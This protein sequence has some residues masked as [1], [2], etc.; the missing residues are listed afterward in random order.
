M[1]RKTQ[2][3]G[4][5]PKAVKRRVTAALPLP[6]TEWLETNGLGGYATMPVH[7][8]RTRRYHSLL[9]V[10]ATE[11]VGRHSLLK[12]ILLWVQTPAGTWPISNARFADGTE[13]PVSEG[14]LLSFS[15]D[16]WPRRQLRLPD[17]TEVELE[18][19]LVHEHNAFVLL[20]RRV[21]GEGPIWLHARPLVAGSQHHKLSRAHEHIEV[22]PRNTNGFQADFSN[23]APPLCLLSNAPWSDEPRWWFDFHLAEEAARGFDSVEDLMQAGV[24]TADIS[25]TEAA[26]VGLAG[27]D[28]REAPTDVLRFAKLCRKAES[29]RRRA[30]KKPMERAADAFVVQRGN[31]KS[32]I[33]GYPWFVDYG[34]DTFI[35][36]RGLLHA[37]G[38]IADAQSVLLNWASLVGTDGSLPNSFHEQ[39]G[40]PL[41][42][43]ADAPLWF[44]LTTAEHLHLAR[45]T[46]RPVD[47]KFLRA[48]ALAVLR[49][50]VR[51]EHPLLKLQD[52]GLVAHGG[53]NSQ[54]TWM[55][56]MDAGMAVTP[57]VGKAVEIQALWLNALA[58]FKKQDRSFEKLLVRGV[59]SFRKRFIVPSKTHLRD[60][61]D[62]DHVAGQDDS[63]LRPNQVFAL[64]GLPLRLVPRA[65]A[66]TM[67]EHVE[68]AL[69]TPHGLRTLDPGDARY[70]AQC[71][72]DS[73]ARDAAYHQGT[74]WP[75]L[76][77]PFVEAWV[78]ARGHSAKA[79]REARK[80]FLKPL[81]EH[82]GSPGLGHM[83][84]IADGDEPYAPRGT[85]FQ[86][87]SLSEAL[88]LD[89]RVLA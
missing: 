42:N 75:W 44:A 68:M 86:A 67:L 13:S 18:N 2:R 49:C 30:F 59:R 77:G 65:T 46:L 20:A 7:G 27:E 26:I 83:S 9:T 51:G 41:L 87:W 64:G 10:A 57:R 22:A 11:P 14:A 32:I 29:R 45:K 23:G 43:S 15:H 80:K 38:R 28:C 12:D 36:L 3:K 56:A 37:T 19:F 85:P 1:K 35:A 21:K 78:A 50:I 89:R 8:A 62:A 58:A 84:E 88:R 39:G 74:A 71:V 5:K 81:M 31:G 4:R 48:A 40:A 66:K 34:R 54:V 6:D 52:D 61:V 24:F 79:K 72:G 63:T 33:A 76:A 73:H 47:A 53:P 17:G 16:P 55:D 82:L 25:K 60:V 70:C 69:L